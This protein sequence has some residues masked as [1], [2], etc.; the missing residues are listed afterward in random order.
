MR[1]FTL[2]MVLLCLVSCV[3]E[4]DDIMTIEPPKEPEETCYDSIQNQG[5]SG[6]DCGGPCQECYTEPTCEVDNNSYDINLDSRSL[7]SASCKDDDFDF[8]IEESPY[9]SS[10]LSIKFDTKPHRSANYSITSSSSPERDEVYIRYVSGSDYSYNEYVYVAES[11]NVHVEVIE[12]ES[13]EEDNNPEIK[14]TFCD[15]TFT[16]DGHTYSG[17]GNLSTTCD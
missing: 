12:D 11:G 4:R 6:I 8:Y 2:L 1:L 15:A 10:H 17:E 9:L 13:N 14:V 7:V 3:P 5:E 16:R